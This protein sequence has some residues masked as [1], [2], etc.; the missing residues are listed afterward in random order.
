MV[1]QLAAE[2]AAEYGRNQPGLSVGLHLDLGE[3]TYR[4]GQWVANYET[5]A[6]QVEREIRF[7][8]DRF[9]ALMGRYPS[10][11]DSHQHVHRN[12]PTRTVT[13]GLSR[14]LGVPLRSF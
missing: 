12:D 7:Q 2:E 4:R 1:R 11:L 14:E 9:V 6:E 3:W 8:V 13:I 5:P 10:H